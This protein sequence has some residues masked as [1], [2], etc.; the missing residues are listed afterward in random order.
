MDKQKLIDLLIKYQEK[1]LSESESAFLK[2]FLAQERA[3]DL[4]IEVLEELS[5]VETP[6]NL[7]VEKQEKMFSEIWNEAQHFSPPIPSRRKKNIFIL[8]TIAAAALLLAILHF[9]GWL[10]LNSSLN[11]TLQKDLAHKSLIVP[12]GTKAQLVL[13][14]GTTLDLENLRNDTTLILN[15]YEIYKDRKGELSYILTESHHSTKKLYNT[16]ITP[17]GGEYHVNLPDGTSIWVNSSS[18]MKYPLQFDRSKRE[19][20]LDGEAY[21]E[22]T[23]QKD[24]E[25]RIPFLV[26]T[27][28]QT[29][30]V[31]GTTF[32]INSYKD[33]IQTTLVEG[34]VKLTYPDEKEHYLA[35]NQQSSY[36]KGTALLTIKEVDPLYFIAWKNGVF[37]FDNASIQDVMD[38]LSRWYEIQVDYKADVSDLKF[39]GTI[40]K[41]EQI[42]KVLKLIEM[43]GSI[44]FKIEE[45][46]IIVMK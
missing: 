13:D 20:E 9:N 4:L 40:S 46:R 42:E 10:G 26:Y 17:K 6:L 30:E 37:A 19:V 25:K 29:L 12:G 18:K 16:I 28:S 27:G 34:K 45:R 21:F 35:P 5:P 36:T 8:S 39:S 11:T 14:N 24:N 1:T 41:Y 2:D 23:K 38:A 43:T 31:L 44:R 22:V 7:S 15:G 32:N 3:N 33:D